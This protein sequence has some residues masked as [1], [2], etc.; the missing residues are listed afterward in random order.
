MKGMFRHL[1]KD[2]VTNRAEL[3][4]AKSECGLDDRK[5][6]EAM[7]KHDGGDPLPWIWAHIR[8]LNICCT[9]TEYIQDEDHE[10]ALSF[11]KKFNPDSDNL[12]FLSCDLAPTCDVAFLH[13]SARMAWFMGR[14]LR[15]WTVLDFARYVRRDL[16][17]KNVEGIQLAIEPIGRSEGSFLKYRSLIEVAYWHL[18]NRVIDGKMRRCAR[19]DCG[20]FFVQTDK[21]Q[22]Y[23]PEPTV[24][25]TKQSLCG[26]K[27]RARQAMKK[28]RRRLKKKLQNK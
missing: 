19:E 25:P 21:R 10:L 14:E 18:H 15:D 9:L 8:T 3:K 27:D 28:Y 2:I 23:C 1:V 20:A 4:A 16:I 5:I 17:N 26:V 7:A 12:E 22:K 24:G 11:L 6:W 13:R